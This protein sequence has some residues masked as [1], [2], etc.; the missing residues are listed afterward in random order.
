MEQSLP[1]EADIRS[2]SQE[3]PC[4]LRNH[5]ISSLVPTLSQLNAFHTPMLKYLKIHFNINLPSTP[6]PPKRSLPFRF[7][8]S[9]SSS[10]SSSGHEVRPI[11]DL[12][13]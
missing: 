2:A 5:K 6:R 12:S 13:V 4:L 8:Y 7:S 3:I 11:N 10:S 1:C 9:S